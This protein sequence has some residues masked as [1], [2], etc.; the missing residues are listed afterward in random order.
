MLSL[1]AAACVA[2][3][4]FALADPI[5]VNSGT[6]AYTFFSDRVEV[7]LRNGTFTADFSW[8]FPRTTPTREGRP[9]D[10][11][12]LTTA[13]REDVLAGVEFPYPGFG[14][15]TVSGVPYT[16]I[17]F[18]GDFTFAGPSFELGP[19]PVPADPLDYP[20]PLTFAGPFTFTASLIGFRQFNEGAPLRD[21]EV[22]FSRDLFGFGTATAR[23]LGSPN[24]QYTLFDVRYDLAP[25]PE[26][27]TLLLVGGSLFAGLLRTR[28]GNLGRRR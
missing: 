18:A 17:S 7:M 28:R 15:A 6:A 2:S 1:A 20:V 16:D 4:P 14:S 22:L 24:Q 8:R 3:P 13:G 11:V 19:V 5:P 10:V 9:G 26:P 21:P 23:Y 27:G 25:V 12:T